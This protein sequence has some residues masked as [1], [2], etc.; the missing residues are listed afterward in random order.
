MSNWLRNLNLGPSLGTWDRGDKIFSHMKTGYERRVVQCTVL[1]SASSLAR[2]NRNDHHH[3]NNRRHDSAL[4]YTVITVLVYYKCVVSDQGSLIIHLVP[5]SLVSHPMTRS[6]CNTCSA[7][8]WETFNNFFCLFVLA[9]L[10]YSES[11]SFSVHLL[12]TRRSHR[13]INPC[14]VVVTSKI[15]LTNPWQCCGHLI[16]INFS[17]LVLNQ[18]WMCVFR[19]VND[20]LIRH[21]LRRKAKPALMDSLLLARHRGISN[22]DT[23]SIENRLFVRVQE[24]EYL[25]VRHLTRSR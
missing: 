18:G 14:V 11:C 6:S 13:S 3:Y 1:L 8:I 21:R 17:T 12:Q 23:P 22:R 15:A 10:A 20:D 9:D 19:L 5:T 2:S 4:S 16:L 7:G 24:I 25:R